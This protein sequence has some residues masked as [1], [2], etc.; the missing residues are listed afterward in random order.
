MVFESYIETDW[1]RAVVLFVVLLFVLRLA[2]S[3]SQRAV[4]R[5]VS[6]TKTDLDDIIIEKASTPIT[7]LLLFV[8]LRIAIREIVLTET[9]ARNFNSVIYTGLV[10][11]IG[12][13]IYVVV[14]VAIVQAWKK[15]AKK[16]KLGS[17]ETLA[18]LIHGFLKIL[19]I[20][21]V[22]IY[23][24]EIWGFAITP[25]LAGLGIAGLAVAL[26]LQPVLSNIFSGISV[27]ADK[28]VSVGDLI[29][30]D[31]N[32][33]GH[34]EEIGLRSTKIKTFDNELLIVPNNK[35]ADGII[36]NVALPEP[37]VR[38]VIPF[39]VAY[40]SNIDKVKNL[41]EKEIK[42]I[43]LASKD[44]KPVIRFTEMA[45]SSLNFK[46]YFY[47]ENFSDRFPAIDEA[48]TKIYNALN[49]AKIE[50]PFPQMDVWLRK[51]KK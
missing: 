34:I 39:S 18:S 35:I 36:Q 12:Y 45:N 5:L 11:C 6:K 8:S 24:L 41:V 10:I 2:A 33:K 22:F 44:P 7:I 40:G 13:L 38:V 17:G 49:K 37:K 16:A 46:A 42:S 14:D 25:V 4:I 48:N 31:A 27:V 28:T 43:K 21:L 1:I 47:V 9:L 3:L 51:A 29:Y 15:L 30:L 26:A 50:I 23:I 19:V 20:V 32:T